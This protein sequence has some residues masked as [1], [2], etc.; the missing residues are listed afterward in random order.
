VVGGEGSAEA[1]G[2]SLMLVSSRSGSK[3]ELQAPGLDKRTRGARE[4]KGRLG[5]RR[6]WA[7]GPQGGA[8]EEMNDGVEGY[9]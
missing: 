1:I 2:R 5:R 9:Y 8:E 6:A 7:D 4:G 3:G